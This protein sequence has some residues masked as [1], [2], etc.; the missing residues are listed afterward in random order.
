MRTFYATRAVLLGF[1]PKYKT[2][3]PPMEFEKGDLDESY[4]LDHIQYV[5]PRIYEILIQIFNIQD[6]IFI[7]K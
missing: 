4:G 5:K 1:G 2:L 6:K 7:N 3:P